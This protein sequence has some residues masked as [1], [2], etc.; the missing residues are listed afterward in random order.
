MPF[1]VGGQAAQPRNLLVGRATE[2]ATIDALLGDAERG[3]AGAL[4]LAGPPG[5]G[6]SALLQYAID[7]ASDFRVVRVT[8]VESEMAFDYAGVH[9]L[10]LP[11]I[12]CLE[13]LPD[14]QRATLDAVL[15]RSEHDAL[16]PFL[17]GLAVLSLVAEAA[18]VEPLLAV[19]DDAQWLDDESVVALSF[20]GR[21]LRAE[22]VASL[23]TMRDSPDTRIRFGGIPTIDVGG[24]STN[25]AHQLLTAAAA[26]PVDEIVA[27][28][29]VAA[30]D[31]NPLVLIEL[32]A[33]LTVEQLRG[34][35]PLPDPFPIGERLAGLFAERARAL[36]A[37]AQMVLLL[38]A[39]E[40]LGD[41][42]LLRRAADA[43]GDL[44]WGEAAA[45]AESSGLVSFTPNAEFRHPLVRSSIYYSAAA[46]DRRRAHA[47]LAEALDPDADA[48]RRAW[49]LGAAATEPD[50]QVA[51][52][53]E[54]SAER[55]RQ[56]GGASAAAFYLWRAAELT[57]DRHRAAERLLEAARAELV[58][59]RGV[60]AREILE[61]ARASGLPKRHQAE[62]A[63][64]EA[65]IQIVAGNVREAAA[66]LAEALPFIQADE[67]AVAVGACVAADAM[68]LLGGYL[69]EEPTR[70][71]IA[72]GTVTV[73][74]R[75]DIPHPIAQMVAGIATGLTAGRADAVTTLR[76]AVADAAQDREQL[77]AAAGR[78]VHVTYLDAILAAADV[79]DERAWGDLADEW[80]QLA[81]RI[82]ALAPLP[83]ALS[84]RSWLE[85]LQGRLGSAASRLAEIEDIVSLTG[86]RGLLGA[87]TPAYVLREAWQ[88]NEEATR[89]GARRMMQDAHERGQGLGVD[90]AYA[91]LTVLE[92]GAGRYEAALR[93]A[94]HLYDHDS[95]VL[96]TL[97]LPDLVESAVRCSD[98][99]LAERAVARLSVRAT[100][101]G[102]PWALALL[103]RGTALVANGDEA[104]AHFRLALD[105]LSRTTITTD[106]ARTQLLYGE[107]L[108]RERRRKEAR[109]PLHEALEFFETVGASGFAARARSELAATGEHVRSRSAPVNVL[110]P[111]EAQIA[112]LAASGERNLDI[113]AQL[114]ITTS[115]VEYHLRK[116][117]VKLGVSSRTQLAQV[118]LPT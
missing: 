2:R 114:Y 69:I 60:R 25:E 113:A 58:G 54:A 62:A 6:K 59:G 30:T 3:V 15:G 32:P 8:G 109:G 33:A 87:P 107:W 104:D 66:L 43:I 27:N 64:T 10:V 89:T 49:H 13:Q 11:L 99:D 50:E 83:L 101:S 56:R 118:D 46:N 111:Q 28:D 67:P 26:G 96:G 73:I 65:L 86:S 61:R 22:R 71:A 31:G 81:R 103:A 52:A 63:W 110:T 106:T 41:P 88:G 76:G 24:L 17:V 12:D 75:C 117:F 20:V 92:L 112:R 70:R 21:R 55:A 37:D 93:T 1:D 48:D 39:A 23:V 90:H 94:R 45:S 98:M 97:A 84:L 14:L 68:A 16:D 78:S 53:L 4:L 72:A 57:P 51:R 47:A 85:V 38:A 91:A 77:Q 29:I 74:E 5:I 95:I 9:Q 116:I 42:M 7:V 36:D 19:I 100:A 35:A 44:S 82:G 18:R 115:T 102:T 108:R 79:L 80:E 105:E 40:R 34:T